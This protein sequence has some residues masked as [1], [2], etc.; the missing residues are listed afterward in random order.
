MG[1]EGPEGLHAKVKE[2]KIKETQPQVDR[3]NVRG[4]RSREFVADWG[5]AG[6]ADADVKLK[7]G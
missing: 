7:S 4:G 3:S 5:I 2:L 1:R 6:D